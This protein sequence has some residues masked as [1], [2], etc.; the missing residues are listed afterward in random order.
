MSD[1][2]NS[3]PD[4]EPMVTV[5]LAVLNGGEVLEHAVRSVMNQSWP[6]WEL[7]LLDDGSTDEAVDCLPF[8]ADPRIVVIR[9]GQNRGLASRLNQAV[10]MAEGK[11]FARMDHDDICHPERFA[12]QVAFLDGHPEV[13]LLATQCLTMDEHERLVGRLP[14]AINHSDICRRPWQGF[15]MAHPSWMG[16]TEWFRRNVYQDPAPYCCEDQE[17]LL[18]ARYSSCY[19]T[20][21]EHLLAYRTRTHTPWK[22]QFRTRI[23]MGKMKVRHFLDREELVNALLSGLIELARIGHDGWNEIRHRLSLPTKV[24][25]GSIPTPEERQEWEALITAIKVSS[26]RSNSN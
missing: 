20:L 11:Y 23:S 25:Q 10:G 22:K 26:E 1:V 16:R 12:R 24:S 2:T 6:H 18:R 19:H 21:P 17:L 15:Y 9:D 4:G 7:L 8:L 3:P 5:A 14:S 13:D